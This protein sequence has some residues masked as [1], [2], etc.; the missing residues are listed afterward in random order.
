MPWLTESAV[1]RGHLSA[2]PVVAAL[3]LVAP[4]VASVV[5]RAFG[6]HVAEDPGPSLLSRRLHPDVVL[7]GLVLPLAAH[8]IT[9]RGDVTASNQDASNDACCG[10]QPV[11]A[12]K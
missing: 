8:C 2:Q 5:G 11:V 9:D 6:E 1:V 3:L 12:V 7:D 10:V 4:G